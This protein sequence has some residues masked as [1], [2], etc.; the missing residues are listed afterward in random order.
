MVGS[1]SIEAG[2]I[3]QLSAGSVSEHT[4][5]VTSSGG[6]VCWGSNNVGQLG[7]GTTTTRIAPVAVSGLANVTALAL[8]AGHT[9]A[10]TAAGGVFCWGDN[11]SGELGDGTTTNRPTPVAVSGLASGVTAIAAGLADTCAVTSGGGVLC[12][13]SNIF[14]Q[15]GDGT[16]TNRTVPV[17]VKNVASVTA[18]AAGSSHACALTSPSGVWCWGYNPYGQLGDGTTLNR[19]MPVQVNGLPSVTALAA[20]GFHTC[21]LTSTGDIRCWGANSLGQLGDG[22]TTNRPAPVAVTG[23]TSVSALAAGSYHTC[24]LTTAGGVSCWG[25][26]SEGQLG[27]G[28]LAPRSTPVGVNG[29]ASGV[30]AIVAGENHTCALTSSETARCWG[31]NLQAQLGDGVNWYHA[32][33]EAVSGMASGVTSISTSYQT[34]A[35]KSGG[36]SCWGFN[37][38]GELGDGTMIDRTTPVTVSGLASGATAIATGETSTCAVATGGA[39]LCWGGNATGQ[40]G[41]GTTTSHLTPMPVTGLASVSAVVIGYGFGCALTNAGTVKCWGENAEGELG[42]N[43]T[44][45]R[46]TPVAVTGLANVTAISAGEFHTC[47]LTTAG[48]VYCWGYNAEGQ[49]GDGTTT[50]RSAPVAVSGLAAG[51]TAISAGG[52][53]TCALT[54]AGTVK[55]WG[56]NSEGQ[57][58]DGTTTNR[59]TPV[60]SGIASV[61]AIGAGLYH[62]CAATV[63]GGVSCWGQNTEG[64]LGDGTLTNRLTPVTVS[65]LAN[66]ST[67]APGYYDTCAITLGGG[68]SCW[69]GNFYGELGDGTAG[70]TVDSVG[71]LLPALA[72]LPAT[73]ITAVTASVG[74]S[75]TADGGVPITVRGVCW[76]TSASPTLTNSCTS[77]GTGS[78]SFTA[79]LTG[80][81][82][83]T[84]YHARAYVTNAQ[85]TF[86]ADDVTFTTI[87]PTMTVDRMALTFA[88]VS[89]GTAFTASTAPQ[90][91]RLTESGGGTVTWTASSNQPWL[92]VSPTSGTGT[93]TLSVS[94]QFMN[95]LAASQSG[96]ITITLT[97]AGNTVGPIS[98]T[99]NVLSGSSPPFG[100]FDTPT[101][102]VTG[103]A[104]SIPVTGWALDAVQ[105][106]RVTICRDAVSGE[107]AAGNPNCAGN[108]QIYIGDAVFVDGARPD[109]QATNPTLPLSSRGGWGYLMLT[110][111]LPNLGNGTFTLRAYAFD[112]AGLTTALGAKTITCANAS[113]TAPFGA[114]DT[115]AQGAVVSGSAFSN[116]G[117]VL[118]KAP[119]FADPPNGG[120]VQV[121]VD[122]SVVGS[123]VGWTNRADLT[124]LFPAASYPGVSSALG[125]FN[126]DTTAFTNGVHTIFWTAV[127]TG[128]SGSAGIGSR[129]ITV[130]NGSDIAEPSSGVIA[131]GTSAVIAA[132]PAVDLP[133]SAVAAASADLSPVPGRRGYDL[134]SALQLYTPSSGRI[135]VQAE[136][137][138]RIELHL[139]RTDHNQ[140]TGYLQTA[141]GLKPLPV[142]SALDASTGTFTWMPGV[143]FYGVYNL[144]FVRWSGG[145]AVARQDVRITLNAKGSNRVGPQTIIDVP[146]EGAAVGSPFYVGGWAAD[147]DSAV[148]SG[149]N[150]VH[151]W[152]YPLDASGH[153]GDP[154]FLGPASY[155]GA[156]PDVAALYGDRFGN[157]GYGIIVDG[158]TPGTYDIA[159][160]AFSTVTNSFTP[161]KVVRVTVR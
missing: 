3:V 85:G 70:L 100:S 158:L 92:V 122:G 67:L 137:L 91:L 119:N 141:G 128:P 106:M 60:T 23:L 43:T 42:D 148:D 52:Y 88:A 109:V 99:L 146:T 50:N 157:S 142:G 104:G 138:D 65:G 16:T 27:S 31:D 87:V 96:S 117:W 147:L 95:G 90:S 46:L 9:C 75:I 5:A 82:P 83:R 102:G 26:G 101:N 7:D 69:G 126:L 15:L 139:G 129:F 36:V 38:D 12:W 118:A 143:G 10:L 47:A 112:A 86:Y 62:T 113:A 77:N 144:T 153:R 37:G 21:V 160:F 155:G 57:L 89:N 28:P 151:V 84:L 51:V 105:V 159:V 76:S 24:A 81:S 19:S 78:G 93:A 29:L 71:V 59:L 134:D 32:T 18:I 25:N 123:P 154:I 61:T 48:A 125:V 156:R 4:C 55:C 17:V 53:F 63:G 66:V 68:V 121:F 161:A 152:A 107:P 72:T 94:T 56:D 2:P 35:V 54:N 58:G 41:D 135:D 136:E 73:A 74:V 140:Y 39:V 103:V 97:G 115:P 34:C 44:T 79:S 131:P 111:F 114:I 22:T 133:S 132:A 108:A 64:E 98:A 40:L 49:L 30:T 150:T 80:L 8:G 33:P 116:F 13:G 11:S 145:T 130:S 20:G 120:A 110:N 6:A 149:V 124:A 1:T 14:G 127:G 45:D